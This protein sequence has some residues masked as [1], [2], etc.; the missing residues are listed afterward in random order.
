MATP[1]PGDRLTDQQRDAVFR[2]EVSVLLSSGAG[3]GKTHVLTRRYLSHLEEDGAAVSQI[4]AITF[5]ERA[6]RQMRD[7]IRKAAQAHLERA[8]TDDKV[9]RWDDHLRGLETAQISTIHAFCGNLLRQHAVEAGLDPRFEILEDYLAANL[10]REALVA[11][12]QGLL[13][14]ETSVGRD[15]RE[16]ILLYGWRS[17]V[18]AVTGLTE[19]SEAAQRLPLA[20]LP[21]TAL[22]ADW[23]ERARRELL[24]RYVRYLTAATPKIARCLWLLRTTPCL[25]PK[26][27]ANVALLLDRLPRLAEAADLAAA[28]KELT[29]AARVGTERAKAWPSEEVYE[30]IKDALT[31]FRD[32]LP[33]R[34][35]L[36]LEEPEDLVT[37]AETGQRFARVAEEAARAYRQLKRRHGVV[38]FDD[39]LVR[40][41][42][43]LRDHPDVRERLQRR[44]QFLLIDELQD[45]DPVQMEFVELLAGAGLTGGRLFAVG[46]HSQSIYRFRQADV[47]LF[48]Q[49][50]RR[51]PHEGRLD[52][53]VNFRSQPAILNFA[54]A[55]FGPGSVPRANDLEDYEPLQPH[56]AQ[57][58]PGSCVEFLWAP[59]EERELVAEA[60][61]READWIA[62]RI[63]TLIANREEL[64]V[65][66]ASGREAL[67][68]VRLGDVVLLFRSMTNV[69]LYET[70]LR[71]HGL[72]YY[73]VGG[74]AFFAQQEIY[75]LLNLLRALENPQDA[76]SLAG[77]LRSPFC[78]LSDEALFVLTRSSGG[79]WA[80][81]HDE[82]VCTRLPN[83][84]QARAA[85]ARRFLDRWHALKDR[86]PIAR[87]LGEIFADSGYDAATQ[88]EF[89]GDRKLANLWKLT[90]MA[91]TFDR[92]GLFGL[93]EFI[94]RLGELVR[95]QPR[96][97]QAA[98]QPESA[99]VVRLMTIHQAKGLEF[100]VVFVPDI[101]A[102]GGPPHRPVAVRDARLG[103][104][105]RP[106]AE[107]PPP[108]TD[109]AWRAWEMAE[110]VEDWREDLRTL[111]VACTRAM[112]YLVLS[113]ALPSDFS[114]QSTWMLALAERFN[115]RTGACLDPGIPV[116]KVP[117]VR[118]ID[119]LCPP[120]ESPFPSPPQRPPARPAPARPAARGEADQE[121]GA[122][123]IVHVAELEATGDVVPVGG[124]DAED[125]SDRREWESPR[126]R[127]ERF[128]DPD[129]GMR[130]RAIRAVL[131][132][133]DYRDPA[134]WEPL[135]RQAL[136]ALDGTGALP[137]PELAEAFR[138]F[139]ATPLFRQLA[140]A[141]EWRRDVEYLVAIPPGERPPGL[142][143]SVMVRGHLDCL[144]RDRACTWQVLLHDTTSGTARGGKRGQVRLA[145]AALAV[146][147]HLGSPPRAVRYYHW[148][149]GQ[150]TTL[151]PA[152][153]R[154]P[155][156]R[157]TQEEDHRQGPGC[158]SPK[159]QRG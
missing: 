122:P 7:R 149:T 139:A 12:L 158:P 5:T 140:R 101:T 77:T 49:L 119:P 22:A 40:S 21:P 117:A 96:E 37:A 51:M 147:E 132:L 75:D 106:P 44:F 3:C 67:R 11:C 14:A 76:V 134:G 91:R 131:G 83:D 138:R 129:A 74:R 114:P 155:A 153:G 113:A 159:R 112:D 125:G 61:G 94:G 85:R 99:D 108:F 18:E 95:S 28:V 65:E 86:L 59:R 73:L 88:F 100:P 25:G 58:N 68:P 97:E 71:R 20:E 27:A 123:R 32:S 102:G 47:K 4:V 154:A 50:K 115:L 127:G 8:A 46:D 107:D 39:L 137:A 64:V 92:S 72:D 60:R 69:Q 16:L 30:I 121:G 38:D 48:Q 1:A 10:R 120:P 90:D 136:E 41:R 52:L 146:R 56:H 143:A 45:T 13:T 156:A 79:P 26:M 70:A 43:L 116:A 31:D 36:F 105:V 33:K 135:L 15:L 53:T 152:R 34:L 151:R 150:T 128:A 130:D 141:S 29:E 78:C 98:T 93:A 66:R 148:Q 57:V 142:P 80:T 9:R 157:T 81:L 2:R 126:E 110:T 124:W 23:R 144:Y 109:F 54:N 24:P 103:C 145:I 133:W 111:Y 17:T 63:A 42:D 84:Q 62:R 35:S 55:L 104:V 82:A 118:V 19:A 6:A 89:L 87:L